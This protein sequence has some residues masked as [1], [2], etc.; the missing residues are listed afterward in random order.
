MVACVTAVAGAATPAVETNVFESAVPVVPE[1][2]IDKLVLAQLA[3]LHLQPT[4]CSDAVFV[5]R[6]YLDTIG[7]LPTAQE[8]REFILDPD[9]RNKRRLLIDRLLAREEFAD[10]WAMKWGDILRIKAE[11]P[12]NLWPNAAQAYHR[13]V[14]ASIAEN[15]PYDQFVRELLTSSGSNFRVGPVNFYRAIQNRTPEGV[16]AAVALT[17]MG[18]RAEAWSK[19]Q[20]AGM[21]AFFSQIG[22]KPTHEWKEENVFWDPLNV[23]AQVTNCLA[24][25]S[26]L[27]PTNCVPQ[28]AI[29]PDGKQIKLPADQDPR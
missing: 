28:V 25:D 8:A 29:F 22:Y 10:Y 18:T 15:K 3:T 4:L 21:A 6:V 14:R 27:P 19:E 13:W 24:S 5:R 23:S 26:S 20:L 9:T 11:F 7:T 2:R 1:G 12:V 16:A 17:F